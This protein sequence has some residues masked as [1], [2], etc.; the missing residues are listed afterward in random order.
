MATPVPGGAPSAAAAPGALPRS[1]PTPDRRL[2]IEDILKLMGADGLVSAAAAEKLAR[3]RTMRFDH[4]LEAIA[5]QKWK[6]LLPP[7]KQMSLDW[8]VEWLGGQL[9]VAHMPIDT[10]EIGLR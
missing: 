8:L 5:D 4:P 6:S 2:R 10:P 9:D 7:H 3:S 1:T